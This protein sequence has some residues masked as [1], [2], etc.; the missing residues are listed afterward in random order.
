AIEV[1]D[2]CFT[3]YSGKRLCELSGY[4]AAYG[5]MHNNGD[6]LDD[7]VAL[8]FKGPKSYTGEDVVELSVHGGRLVVKSVLRAVLESGADLAEAGEFT[9]RAF[10]NGKLDLSRAESVMSI[11]SAGNDTALR[12]SRAAKDGRVSREIEGIIEQLLETAASIAVYSDYPDEDILGLNEENFLKMLESAMA[13]TEN[14]LSTYDAGKVVRE[15]IDCAI[16]GKPNV[17]KSTLMNLLTG[18]DRSIVTDIAGTTRDVI[19]E[20][21]TLGDITLRLADTAGIHT[22]S[23]TVENVGVERAK[24]KLRDADLIFAV[25]DSAAGLDTDDMELIESIKDRNSIVILNKTDLKTK[26]DKSVFEELF[27][28]EISAKK[29]EGIENLQK[30]VEEITKVS[31]IDPNAA[32]LISEHQRACTQRAYTALYEGAQAFS[33]GCTLDAVGVCIDDALA[34]LL[35]LT[36]KRVTNEVTDEIFRRFCVGK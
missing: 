30:A 8:V 10:L 33:M 34:A 12:I 16:V 3:A 28:V 23:D 2:K 25:F 5:K 18:T 7:G 1:A 13:K 26:I 20:T 6:K 27:V 17:G 22:T 24:S 19:E 36:G 29:G 32:V 9:K 14:L 15:G 4:E 21:V 35:E 11:I 31:L